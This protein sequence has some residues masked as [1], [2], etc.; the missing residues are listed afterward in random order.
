MGAQTGDQTS[1]QM[2][3]KSRIP[4]L[5]G[6]KK[7]A[8]ACKTESER[9]RK[10]SSLM[11]GLMGLMEGLMGL[12]G[13]L[14]GLIEGLTGLMEGLVGLNIDRSPLARRSI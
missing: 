2:S 6:N 13:G 1:G 12:L 4:T 9:H 10:R 3:A 8:A 14:M 5:F 11:E 7:N